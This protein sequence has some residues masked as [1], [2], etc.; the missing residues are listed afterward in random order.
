MT[1]K[2]IYHYP[3]EVKEEILKKLKNLDKLSPE[4]RKFRLE[5]Y[6]TMQQ[7]DWASVTEYSKETFDS[8]KVS[9]FEQNQQQ[10]QSKPI[11]IK[12][13]LSLLDK[14]KREAQKKGLPYQTLIKSILH[15]AMNET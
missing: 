13:P 5:E 11:T 4:E 9:E 8:L 2:T 10:K 12:M 14:L 1:K 6:Q 7:R 15:Q 3:D